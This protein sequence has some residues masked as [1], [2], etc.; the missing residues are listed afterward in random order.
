MNLYGYAGGDPINNHDP[1]GLDVEAKDEK[2]DRIYKQLKNRA[3][4]MA[5]STDDK[6]RDAGKALLGMISDLEGMDAVVEIHVDLLQGTKTGTLT[7]AYGG[8]NA[9]NLDSR[10]FSS[11]SPLV[12]LAHE[13][14]H[15]HYIWKQGNPL[16]AFTGLNPFG[17]NFRAGVRAEN[18]MRAYSG[19]GKRFWHV[20]AGPDC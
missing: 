9:V 11:R 1:F 2:A 16:T 15:A 20:T 8:G 17:G 6:R 19:C 18:H 12:L 4:V 7:S 14:G 13:L 3:H 10:D 5:A